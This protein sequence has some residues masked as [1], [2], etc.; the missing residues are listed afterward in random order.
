MI[1]HNEFDSVNNIITLTQQYICFIYIL[2]KSMLLYVMQYWWNDIL[3]HQQGCLN[4]MLWYEKLEQK[5][6]WYVMV[7]L[8]I[9]AKTYPHR[10][11]SNIEEKKPH[12]HAQNIHDTTLTFKKRYIATDDS[13]NYLKNISRCRFHNRSSVSSIV[14][15]IFCRTQYNYNPHAKLW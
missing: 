3:L 11:I 14:R 1:W 2:Y 12:K 10:G 9:W 7:C 15:Y 6:V 4:C 13:F 8:E 5:G